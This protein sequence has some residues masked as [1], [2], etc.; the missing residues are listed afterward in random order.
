MKRRVFLAMVGGTVAAACASPASEP[1]PAGCAEASPNAEGLYCLV[2]GL[3]VRVPGG[4]ALVAGEAVLANVDDATAVLLGRDDA[5]FFARSAICTHAC[6]VVSLC[7]GDD[8][9]ALSPTPPACGRGAVVRSTSAL[10]PCHGSI[11]RLS[12]GAPLTGPAKTPLPAFALT[13]DG[14]DLV[15]DTGSPVDEAV[16]FA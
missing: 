3:L 7:G 4:A 2:D 8:C 1:A 12:D 11:F 6:C 9:G 16:R 13:R 15:V 10:C 5:G 14:D